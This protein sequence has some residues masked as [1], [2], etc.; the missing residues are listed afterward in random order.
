M[1]YYSK[2]NKSLDFEKLVAAMSEYSDEFFSENNDPTTI[3]ES[4]SDIAD[5]AGIPFDIDDYG[6]LVPKTTINNDVLIEDAPKES[7]ELAKKIIEEMEVN[8]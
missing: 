4:E 1:N 3:M 6:M 7:I 2:L 8:Q 5:I